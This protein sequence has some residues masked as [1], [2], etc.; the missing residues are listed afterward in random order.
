MDEVTAATC[1]RFFDA[2]EQGDVEA[3]AAV[4]AP[5]A[6]IWHNTDEAATSREASIAVLRDIVRNL[7][8]RRYADRR[9]ATFATGFVQQHV[10]IGQMGDGTTFRLPACVVATVRDGLITRL[11][12]YY[13]RQTVERQVAQVDPSATRP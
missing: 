10:L 1:R 6:V 12:E 9:V 7:E 2:I 13:D 11:D 5:D 4:Y 3:A 8:D